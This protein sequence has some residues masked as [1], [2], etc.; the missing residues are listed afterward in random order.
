M[1]KI[2]FILFAA[3]AFVA[4][5]LDGCKIV[6]YTPQ[7][8]KLD[9]AIGGNAVVTSRI[10]TYPAYIVPH[11]NGEQPKQE[12]VVYFWEKYPPTDEE[13]Q[14]TRVYEVYGCKISVSNDF[15]QFN[16]EVEED[17]E[18]D[19]LE[20]WTRWVNGYSAPSKF[21]IVLNPELYDYF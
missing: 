10:A 12:N 1:K 13:L 3:L 11:I 6:Q 4:C 21:Y 8:V 7:F 15:K 20:V 5:D 2:L 19:Y 9:G 16:I 17:C 18:W 14:N